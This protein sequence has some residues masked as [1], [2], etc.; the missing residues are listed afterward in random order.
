MITQERRFL[1]QPNPI[2]SVINWSW[3]FMVLLMGA[4][5]WLEVTHFNW[6]TLGFFIAFAVLCWAEIHFRNVTMA[7]GVLMVSTVLNHRHLVIPLHQVSSVQVSRYRLGIVAQGKIYQ[8]LLPRNS[9]IEL[10]GL[11][12]TAMAANERQEETV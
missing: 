3:T 1:Y 2:S 12:Q 7:N 8:F 9:V 4:I 5:F 6:Y 11:I 10:A